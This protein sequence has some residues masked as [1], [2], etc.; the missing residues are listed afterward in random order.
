MG[1]MPAT[2]MLGLQRLPL[3]AG[4]PHPQDRF[5]PSLPFIVDL[6]YGSVLFP[7]RLCGLLLSV[8]LARSQNTSGITSADG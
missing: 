7:A 2:H 3:L 5:F 1:P 4:K 8:T 6:I